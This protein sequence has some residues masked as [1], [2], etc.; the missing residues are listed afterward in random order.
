MVLNHSGRQYITAIDSLSPGFLIDA[1]S[2]WSFDYTPTWELYSNHIF[3]NTVDELAN[4]AANYL[5]H[6]VAIQ[7][8]QAY[9]YTAQPL[10][11]TARQTTEEDF[12]TSLDFS[13]HLS[14]QILAE[15]TESQDLRYTVGYP[16]SKEW[17]TT[18]WLHYQVFPQL[19][20]AVGYGFGYIAVSQGTDISYT[21]PEIQ[22]TWT[23]TNKISINVMGG[24]DQPEFLTKPR[25]TLD[26]PYI[27][28]ICNTHR[29]NP[30]PLP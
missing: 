1:G 15:S 21:R 3:H 17:S 30:Q 28:P 7:F 18:E 16:S 26:T 4:L 5:I 6:D 20:T 9:I 23:V 2:H 19:D 24:L 25:G 10:I 14:R 11:E 13:F 22:M 12:A 29:F 8:T 27:V